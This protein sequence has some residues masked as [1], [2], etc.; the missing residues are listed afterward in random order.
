[1]IRYRL[2]FSEPLIALAA[3]VLLGPAMLS[4]LNLDWGGARPEVVEQLAR[5]AVGLA[6]VGAALRLPRNYPRGQ[7]R[8]LVW[9][10]GPVLVLMAATG[11]LILW[12]LPGVDLGLAAVLGAALAPTDPVLAGSIVTGRLAKERLPARLRQIISGESGANDGVAL[13]LVMLPILLLRHPAS[14]AMFDWTRLIF[15]EIVLAAAFGWLV[16]WVVGRGEGYV[17]RDE[18]P[19]PDSLGVMAIA[20]TLL[21][22]GLVRWAG[23]D[24]ILAAF[25]AALAYRR[26]APEK[27]E[28]Q[29]RRFQEIINRLAMTPVAV[30]LGVIL[31]WHRWMEMGWPLLL[32]ALAIPVLRRLPWTC[33]LRSRIGAA[34]RPADAAF[35]GLFGPVGLAALFYCCLASRRLDEPRVF[36]IGSAVIAASFLVHGIAAT[37][38]TQRMHPH[39]DES[40]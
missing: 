19:T 22:L 34:S 25:A 28:Q 5:I 24:G 35:L 9:M 20:L 11:T 2:P 31:P 16:G 23:G 12:A 18:L 40:G 21:L 39:H 4:L 13:A 27:E 36:I 37:P 38:L 7:L 3:G 32:A 10:L 17:E 15:L 8:D 6:V 14:D 26:T 1:M 30:V 33:L 29:Q